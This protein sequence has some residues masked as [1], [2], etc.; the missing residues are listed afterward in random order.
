M[1]TN[2]TNSKLSL[3]FVIHIWCDNI[4]TCHSSGIRHSVQSTK[5][6][7]SSWSTY[8]KSTVLIR[9]CIITSR[10]HKAIF[11]ATKPAIDWLPLLLLCISRRLTWHPARHSH[12][13]NEPHSLSIYIACDFHQ[14]SSCFPVRFLLPNDIEIISVQPMPF[15][16]IYQQM[17]TY[18]NLPF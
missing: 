10:L 13:S 7:N 8:R 9:N 1:A 6:M 5:W 11:L 14:F 18:A 3:L 12:P 4:A 17:F 15:K 16:K 2:N